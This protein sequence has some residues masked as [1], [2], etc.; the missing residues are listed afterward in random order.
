VRRHLDWLSLVHPSRYLLVRRVLVDHEPRALDRGAGHELRI[1]VVLIARRMPVVKVPGW[2]IERG[3]ADQNRTVEG[4]AAAGMT[5]GQIAREL[6][7]TRE[8]V[9]RKLRKKK[10][11]A[12]GAI[13]R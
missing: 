6:G 7:L 1:G 4:L 12:N 5:P 2:L 10:Q 13:P 9:Q 8:S 3:N 11:R